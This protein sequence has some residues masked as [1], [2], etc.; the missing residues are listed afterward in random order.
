MTIN[1]DSFAEYVLGQV[2][3]SQ[4]FK[5]QVIYDKDGDCIEFLFSN[6]PFYG[7]RID[8]LVTVYYSEETREI[9]GSLIKGVK[10]FISDVIKKVP[11]FRIDVR[12]GR[13][14]LE[15][16]FTAI[17]WSDPAMDQPEL[18][19]TYQKLR[20]KAEKFAAEADLELCCTD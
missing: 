17:L 18:V 7:E 15:H 12:D 9:V 2:D 20:D 5:P 14:K 10:R 13:I 8:S 3:S 19:V 11:G 6:E 16:L 1:N 4:P